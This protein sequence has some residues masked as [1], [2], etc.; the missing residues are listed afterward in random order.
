MQFKNMASL[1]RDELASAEERMMVLT[2]IMILQLR[3]LAP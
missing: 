2:I 1:F 3:Q